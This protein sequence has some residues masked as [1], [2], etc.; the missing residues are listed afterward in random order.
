M[1]IKSI[2]FLPDANAVGDTYTDKVGVAFIG[3][4]STVVTTS[5]EDTE[6]QQEENNDNL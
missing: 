3:D 4:A 6:E 5:E 1:D 2:R